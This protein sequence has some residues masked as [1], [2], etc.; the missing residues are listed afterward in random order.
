M[1]PSQFDK[2]MHDIEALAPVIGKSV[3]HIREENS[4]VVHS[5]QKIQAERLSAFTAEK[6]ARMRNRQFHATLTLMMLKPLQSIHLKKFSKALWTEKQT[7]EWFQSKTALQEVYSK[8]TTISA[9][10]KT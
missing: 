3:A 5:G 10:L 9:G 8:T 1:L 6:E 4:S 2:M 7:T